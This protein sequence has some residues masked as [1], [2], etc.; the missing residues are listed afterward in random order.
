MP[1]QDLEGG[2][3]SPWWRTRR[4]NSE[5]SACGLR[6]GRPGLALRDDRQLEHLVAARQAAA[7]TL[8]DHTARLVDER[9]RERT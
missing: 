1:L 7:V 4:L 6:A 9:E 8:A 5:S 2:A 3:N